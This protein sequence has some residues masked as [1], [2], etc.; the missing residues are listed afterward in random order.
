MRTVVE[1]NRLLYVDKKQS[2]PVVAEAQISSD[3]TD[4]VLDTNLAQFN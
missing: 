2:L 3:V 1:E 4:S